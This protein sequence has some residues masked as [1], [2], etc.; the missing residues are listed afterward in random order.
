MF[1]DWQADSPTRDLGPQ[2]LSSPNEHLREHEDKL[3][4]P[5]RSHYG[6][7]EPSHFL[8]RLNSLGNWRSNAFCRCSSICSWAG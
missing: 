1:A 6:L 4:L 7:D 5:V 8:S 3:L 2:L